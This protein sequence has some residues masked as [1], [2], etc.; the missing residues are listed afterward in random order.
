M[1]PSG[2]GREKQLFVGAPPW[3]EAFQLR[4]ALIRG[5]APLLRIH[6][7]DAQLT[8]IRLTPPHY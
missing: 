7:G 2:F 6:S 8:G 3:C 1:K 4:I 5:E